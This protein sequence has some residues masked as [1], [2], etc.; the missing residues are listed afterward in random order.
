MVCGQCSRPVHINDDL[1]ARVEQ[2]GL[3]D[4]IKDCTILN[5]R[6]PPI[7]EESL[8][9]WT[10]PEAARKAIQAHVHAT[11]K[12]NASSL[13]DQREKEL[14]DLCLPHI[15]PLTEPS[16]QHP[17]CQECAQDCVNL[18]S[19]RINEVKA[20]VDTLTLME[21]EM[22][23]L[24]LVD[25][26]LEMSQ[27]DMNR[28]ER[29]QNTVAQKISTMNAEFQQIAEM[30][31][32]YDQDYE[33]LEKQK[34]LLETKEKELEEEKKKFWHRHER[35][36]FETDKLA[37]AEARLQARIK[38][39]SLILASLQST[40]AYMDTFCIEEDASGMGTINELRLG[41]GMQRGGR[42]D[43]VEWSEINAA[44][45]QVAL[46]L[47]VLERLMK[48]TFKEYRVLPRCSISC[49]E[50]LGPDKAIY[51]LYGTNDWHIG[52]LLHSRRFDHGMVG[53][54]TCVKELGECA[55]SNDPTFQ[56][57]YQYVV[58]F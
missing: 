14:P 7:F 57:P 48:Y 9:P 36:Q 45:G 12:P 51:E 31:K 52:R 22:E 18:L 21:R 4:L 58:E 35:L 56:L 23:R 10:L 43:Q 39:E 53:I 30:L 50:A 49:I 24:A 40:N 54:L 8:E 6:K 47:T 17:M 26:D 29:E 11:Q 33:S 25:G 38:N 32:S 37:S 20:E 34:A 16:I 13:H 19:T 55:S 5:E 42:N 28:W 46:L 1:F 44:L 41:R 2:D 3:K 15:P 27:E